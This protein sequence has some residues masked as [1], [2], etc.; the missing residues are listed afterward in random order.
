MSMKLEGT[1]YGMAYGVTVIQ[2]LSQTSFAFI[3]GNHLCLYGTA[4]GNHLQP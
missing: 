3:L 2:D 4:S 1:F